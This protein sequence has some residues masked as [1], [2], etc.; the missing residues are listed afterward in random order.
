[1][2]VGGETRRSRSKEV[3]VESRSFRNRTRDV[4]RSSA[5]VNEA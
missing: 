2:T 1:M 4:P 5:Q 3:A